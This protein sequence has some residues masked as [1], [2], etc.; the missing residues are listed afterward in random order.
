MIRKTRG[1]QSRNHRPR[2]LH[3]KTSTQQ[4]PHS[5]RS[6]QTAVQ[7]PPFRSPDPKVRALKKCVSNLNAAIFRE[8]SSLLDG[9]I[10]FPTSALSKR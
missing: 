7:K 9:F 2:G 5:H 1:T 8:I 3:E 10:P 4:N 6:E